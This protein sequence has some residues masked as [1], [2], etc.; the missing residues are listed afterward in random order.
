MPYLQIKGLIPDIILILSICYT[1]LYSLQIGM[2]VSVFSGLL[3]DALSG[4]PV[5]IGTLSRF[6]TVTLVGILK[7]NVYVRTLIIMTVVFI[8]TFIK[9]IL[10]LLIHIL[11]G[12]KLYIG[13]S[14]LLIF[15]K[16]LYNTIFSPVVYFALRKVGQL[17]HEQDQRG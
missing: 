15:Y 10:F 2:A 7:G 11:F 1:L 12:T 6:L 5:G 16:M 3:L 9:E 13:S 4:F 14:L 17:F 8:T